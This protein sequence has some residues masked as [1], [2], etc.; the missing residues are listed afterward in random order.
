MNHELG[1]YIVVVACAIALTGDRSLFAFDSVSVGTVLQ[2]GDFLQACSAA[3]RRRRRTPPPHTAAMAKRKRE[4]VC[5]IEVTRH[6]VLPSPP[7]P[8]PPPSLTYL[9]LAKTLCLAATHSQSPNCRA[10]CETG[11]ADSASTCTPILFVE[12]EAKPVPF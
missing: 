12:T 6:D 11:G 9:K 8:P 7:P 4:V 3:A 1:M 2:G 5:Q 10:V